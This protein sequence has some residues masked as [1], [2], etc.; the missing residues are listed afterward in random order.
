MKRKD[1]EG[2]VLAG[3]LVRAAA[4]AIV[5]AGALAIPAPALAESSSTVVVSP[6]AGDRLRGYWVDIYRVGSYRDAYDADA[7]GLV[8]SV[9][10]HS[11]DATTDAWVARALAKASV[12]TDANYDAAGNYAKLAEGKGAAAEQVKVAEALADDKTKP[13]PVLSDVYL[14]NAKEGQSQTLDL[15]QDGLY[16][17]VF[18]GHDSVP[19]VV[20]TKVGGSDM[21]GA[22]L[23]SV[24]LKLV[25]PYVDKKIYDETGTHALDYDSVTVGDVRRFEA[26]LRVPAEGASLTSLSYA[27]KPRGM[28]Y[29]DGTIACTVDGSEAKV[30]AVAG[31]DGGFTVDLTPLID[32]NW[33][34]TVTLTWESKV[35]EAGATN[36][37]EVEGRSDSQYWYPILDADRVKTSSF[38]FELDK[39]RASDGS[40]LPGAGF[41]VQDSE[42]GEWMSWD[43]DAKEWSFAPDEAG[44]T[45][46]VS[47]DAGKVAFSSL[48]AGSYLVKETTVPDGMLKVVAP[49][50]KVTIDRT[51]GVTIS[52][53]SDSNLTDVSK[54][55]VTVQNVDSLTMLPQT[56]VIPSALVPLGSL[57]ALAG[58]AGL[59]VRAVRRMRAEGA[60]GK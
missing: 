24:T 17:I 21:E 42:T 12:I 58:G 57:L 8:D 33:G 9:D 11:P 49:S 28:A 1:S 55:V 25:R 36:D 53:E 45:E 30:S 7:D 60:S 16:L 15:G 34:K 14:H 47:D 26:T 32:G 46:L 59:G 18:R 10:V 51:G 39:V 4:A 13:A 35:T 41:K 54:G 19:I 48:G 20:S 2:L 5:V 29:V 52:D 23:G 22:T 3:R 37:G 40:A 38:D 6:S 56:G 44:A 27:D 50:F 31:A 43:A